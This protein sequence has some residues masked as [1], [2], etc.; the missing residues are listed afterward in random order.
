MWKDGVHIPRSAL[1]TKKRNMYLKC[2]VCKQV[3]ATRHCFKG[4]RVNLQGGGENIG[5]LPGIK[6]HFDTAIFTSTPSRNGYIGSHNFTDDAVYKVTCVLTKTM[7]APDL[8]AALKYVK[9]VYIDRFHLRWEILK[10][11]N[12]SVMTSHD[13]CD[14]LRENNIVVERSPTDTPAMNGIAEMTNKWLGQATMCALLGSGLPITFWEDAY[15]V[16][17]LVINMTP[18]ETVLGYGAPMQC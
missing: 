16:S 13:I 6:L 9:R 18:T 15:L 14:W 4:H 17:E 11:D 10:T 3:K 5:K 12:A 8:L 2:S 1:G 7:G